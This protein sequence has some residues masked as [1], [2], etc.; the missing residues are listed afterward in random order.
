MAGQP[1][2][3]QMSTS[4]KPRR[5]WEQH[6]LAWHIFNSQTMESNPLLLENFIFFFFFLQVLRKTLHFYT[7]EDLKDNFVSPYINI[8]HCKP[9][10]R[11]EYALLCTEAGTQSYAL[12]LS[13]LACH[14]ITSKW[15][16][17]F[18]YK[19]F[20][21]PNIVI[22]NRTATVTVCFPFHRYWVQSHPKY[23][24]LTFKCSAW[25]EMKCIDT[26]CI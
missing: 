18:V 9:N 14:F 11:R 17:Q 21:P 26:L 22:I 3:R 13:C 25:K 10:G 16:I 4:V 23:L 1:K 20:N 15:T 7:A 8:S 19:T 6:D 12:L 5:S 2:P 24:P